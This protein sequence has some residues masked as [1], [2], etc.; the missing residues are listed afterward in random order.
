MKNTDSV[1]Q[2]LITLVNEWEPILRSLTEETITLR[3]NSQNRTI[4]QILGHIVDSASNNTHRIVHLQ[5]EPSPLIF[6]NYATFGNNDRWIAIQDYQNEDWNILIHLWKY[7]LMHIS[8]VIKNIKT[9]K[10]SNEW[11]SGPGEKVTLKSM[12]IDFPRHLKLHLS[13][14]NELINKN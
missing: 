1:S 11:I 12:I 6:P 10:L 2:E 7:S 14:I 13:E 4:K 3:R 5:Y 8:H 9:D